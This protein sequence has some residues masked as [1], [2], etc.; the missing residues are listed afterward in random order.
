MGADIPAVHPDR[1]VRPGDGHATSP[2]RA[3]PAREVMKSDRLHADDTPIR[4]LD[5]GA[6]PPSGGAR[7]VKEGRI[8]VY[9]RNDRPWA[10]GDPPGAAYWFC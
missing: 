5:P 7:G 3:D 1:L 2:D 9:V 4:V 6:A 10:G 8:W